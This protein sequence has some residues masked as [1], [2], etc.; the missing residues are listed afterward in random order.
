MKRTL[1]VE[2]SPQVSL[3]SYPHNY[4]RSVVWMAR[5]V[6]G[7][8]LESDSGDSLGDQDRQL[9]ISALRAKRW[10]AFSGGSFHFSVSDVPLSTIFSLSLLQLG[11]IA[12]EAP[13]IM[14]FKAAVSPIAMTNSAVFTLTTE[15]ERLAKLHEDMQ[16]SGLPPHQLQELLLFGSV[17]DF[18]Y[19]VSGAELL[20]LC[21]VVL[22]Q[23]D[24]FRS[25]AMM[26]EMVS[27]LLSRAAD[28]CPDVF[29]LA[30]EFLNG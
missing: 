17:A 27:E 24:N 3:I 29:I 26:P 8:T 12:S 18:E 15:I 4:A 1:N 13:E 21:E 9:V 30:K 6:L 2:A 10:W 11:V 7:N 25:D 19:T 20:R 22:E 14:K 16:L 23:G 28:V 5:R